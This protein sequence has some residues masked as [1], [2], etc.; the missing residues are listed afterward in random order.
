LGFLVAIPIDYYG[1]GGPVYM[2]NMRT[3]NRTDLISTYTGQTA[4]AMHFSGKAFRKPGLFVWGTYAEYTTIDTYVQQWYHRKIMV[5]EIAANP[6]IYSITS[7]HINY[8]GYWTE[9]HACPNKDL[10]RI[11]FTSSWDDY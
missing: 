10:T 9:P 3:G 4:A 1:Y 8:G 7:I 11:A 6:R 2:V 5:V